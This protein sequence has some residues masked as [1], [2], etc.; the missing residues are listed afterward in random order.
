MPLY[1]FQCTKCEHTFEEKAPSD[2]PFPACPECGEATE[3]MITAPNFKVSKKTPKAEYYHKKA[4]ENWKAE[5]SKKLT[6][7]V[8]GASTQKKKSTTK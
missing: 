3:K 1:D 7:S 6:L 2:G 5:N 8:A 4:V